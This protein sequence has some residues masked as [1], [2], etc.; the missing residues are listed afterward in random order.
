MQAL[1]SVR[2][3]L[4]MRDGGASSCASVEALSDADIDSDPGTTPMPSPLTSSAVEDA[5]SPVLLMV[6]HAALSS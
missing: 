6:F 3:V 2:R 1:D 4:G 5:P